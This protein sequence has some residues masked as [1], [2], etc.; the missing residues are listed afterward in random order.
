MIFDD[1]QCTERSMIT[2]VDLDVPP[3][4][5]LRPWIPILMKW[6]PDRLTE[7]SRLVSARHT[8]HLALYIV[9]LVTSSPGP[10]WR[11]TFTIACRHLH[12]TESLRYNSFHH[13][14]NSNQIILREEHYWEMDNQLL[15]RSVIFDVRFARLCCHWCMHAK[16]FFT[17]CSPLPATVYITV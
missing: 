14:G 4:C 15:K 13:L 11:F 16:V 12:L 1:K 9:S 10:I 5:V 3:A 17:F 6:F 7:L 8:S 2:S